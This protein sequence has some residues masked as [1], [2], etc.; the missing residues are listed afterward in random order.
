MNER[1]LIDEIKRLV[2]DDVIIGYYN[3][4]TFT[5]D[6]GRTYSNL[7]TNNSPIGRGFIVP[8]NNQW[9]V[10]VANNNQEVRK[11]IITSR[12]K[13]EI[14]DIKKYPV[15]TIFALYNNATDVMIFYF[16]GDRTSKQLTKKYFYDYAYYPEVTRGRITNLGDDKHLINIQTFSNDDSFVQRDN[17]QQLMKRNRES[18]VGW[19]EEPYKR[20]YWQEKSYLGYNYIE[21]MDD[22]YEVRII[23]KDTQKYIL[24]RTRTRYEPIKDSQNRDVPNA[25]YVDFLVKT[26]R[27]DN[28][29]E[30]ITVTCT[31][32]IIE[33]DF[34]IG[35]IIS[36]VSESSFDYYHSY[37]FTTPTHCW[38]WSYYEVQLGVGGS[39]TLTYDYN[40]VANGNFTP[41]LIANLQ[42][43]STDDN[44]ITLTGGTATDPSINNN[45]TL[46]A[47]IDL[48]DYKNDVLD[49]PPRP[50]GSNTSST[51]ITPPLNVAAYNL[52]YLTG[53]PYDGEESVTEEG[54]PYF[55]RGRLKKE[56]V[57]N[58]TN[59]NLYNQ[60]NLFGFQN[61]Y[62]SV[63]IIDDPNTVTTR[64]INLQWNSNKTEFV[65]N[66]SV[67]RTG[68][69]AAFCASNITTGSNSTTV[70]GEYISL[71]IYKV[72]TTIKIKETVEGK[73][74]AMFTS[75]GEIVQ[76]Y[77]AYMEYDD[78]FTVKFDEEC[79]QKYLKDKYTTVTM[80]D[81]RNI[82][83]LKYDDKQ[84]VLNTNDFGIIR[85]D[86]TSKVTVSTLTKDS[87]NF[88]ITISD[89]F[90]RYIKN[91]TGKLFDPGSFQGQDYLF[92]YDID[93]KPAL[94]K[95]MIT[96]GNYNTNTF[97]FTINCTITSI[98]LNTPSSFYKSLIINNGSF[99]NYYFRKEI[100]LSKL[101]Y[102]AWNES[103]PYFLY[104]HSTSKEFGLFLNKSVIP[105][106]PLNPSY[107]S[108]WVS[109]RNIDYFFYYD[110]FEEL[111]DFYSKN[112]Y[113][114]NIVKNKIYSVVKVE[115][116]KAWI[117]KWN[118]LENGDVKYSKVFQVDY[119]PTKKPN[120]DEELTIYGHSYYPS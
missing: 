33:T 63:G 112:H 70:I 48:T 36:Y 10:V 83:T 106:I 6:N 113:T 32:E 65:A 53:S 107:L 7:V 14:E 119:V 25:Y 103:K 8:Y 120:V 24:A 101:P 79:Q 64:V 88:T 13:N 68:L 34:D 29:E 72:P 9:L 78:G 40:T 56:I 15:K 51:T 114:D 5:D 97:V 47:V 42:S 71:G 21:G 76:D 109:G 92:S 98:K 86:K 43:T 85:V 96:S 3:G 91:I 2:N 26:L 66:Y 100:P 54:I 22:H 49:L 12:R 110:W 118:I 87:E 73:S 117:E 115:N 77:K 16:G 46:N 17:W 105:I 104:Q 90:T 23:Y 30:N 89:E 111:K 99:Y 11:N 41:G 50:S 52:Y 95:G 116:N 44:S 82:L 45:Y 37:T 18:F 67:T 38:W 75:N 80:K 20:P 93:E 59:G 57:N 108:L 58:I 4:T 19:R 69:G 62:N 31:S 28:S 1:K 94:I 74:V 61:P 102:N 35:V 84:I 27:K 81:E 39:H 60:D 55:I